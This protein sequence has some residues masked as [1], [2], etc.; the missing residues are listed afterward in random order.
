MKVGLFIAFPVVVKSARVRLARER[1]VF[2]QMTLHLQS[3]TPETFILEGSFAMLRVRQILENGEDL[4]ER[5]LPA[6]LA[7]VQ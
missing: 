6:V 4:T 3:S 5:T 7:S 2:S 1:V